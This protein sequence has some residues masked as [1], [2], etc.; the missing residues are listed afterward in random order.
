LVINPESSRVTLSVDRQE[1]FREFL[2]P[3]SEEQPPRD[4]SV[5]GR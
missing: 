4:D 2:G 3:I 5:L 1:I